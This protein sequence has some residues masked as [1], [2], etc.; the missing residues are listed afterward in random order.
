[1]TGRVALDIA[2]TKIKPQIFWI[3]T[4]VCVSFMGH[5]R[6]NIPAYYIRSITDIACSGVA[7]RVLWDKKFMVV[8]KNWQQCQ[9]RNLPVIG[10]FP[11]QRASNA[12]NVSIWWRYHVCKRCS[13]SMKL[14]TRFTHCFFVVVVG[15]LWLHLRADSRLP[16]SQ[17]EASLQNNATSHW[18]G[19]NLESALHF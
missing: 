1:M 3:V 16:P 15:S 6:E 17:W 9:H 8:C 7:V 18:L 14:S 2:A 4:H 19:A 12:G 13:T 11:S 5:R 10:G